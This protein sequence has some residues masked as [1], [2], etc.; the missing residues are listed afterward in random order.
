MFIQVLNT[1]LN[2]QK[3]LQVSKPVRL[4]ITLRDFIVIATERC[5]GK[6]V[7]LK[8]SWSIKLSALFLAKVLDI[9]VKKFIFRIIL[10]ILLENKLLY[11]F[12]EFSSQ[13]SKQLFLRTLTGWFSIRIHICDAF[14]DLI[15]FVSLKKRQNRLWKGIIF[16]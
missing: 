13:F 10:L 2:M 15:P 12:K 7:F 5:F 8:N 1:V 6:K 3:E 16:R 11:N 4:L 14:S 9:P